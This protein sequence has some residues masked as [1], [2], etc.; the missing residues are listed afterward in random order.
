MRWSSYTSALKH[1]KTSGKI[2][3]DNKLTSYQTDRSKKRKAILTFINIDIVS[4]KQC[5]QKFEF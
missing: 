4:Q 2:F 1:A 5:V 3:P